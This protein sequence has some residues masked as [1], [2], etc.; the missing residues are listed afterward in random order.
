[1]FITDCI[2][3]HRAGLHK[4]LRTYLFTPWSRAPLEKLTGSAAS[5]EIPRIFGTRRF[6]TYPQAPATCPYPDPTPSSPHHPLPLPEDSS[7]LANSLAT[8]VRE[9]ALYRLLTF[10]VPKTMSLFLLRDTSSRNTPP[11]RTEWGSSLPPD[12]FV[13]RGSISTSGYFLTWLFTGRRC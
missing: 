11:R 4:N 10:H 5:Q 13:S 12:F 9:P 3:G 7:Y 8:A 1:M 2:C 6:L